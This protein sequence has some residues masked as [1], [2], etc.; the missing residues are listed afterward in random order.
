VTTEKDAINLG[1]FFSALQ[2]LAVVPVKMDLADAS[3]A[4]DTM[5]RILEERK[6][7]P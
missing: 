1:G 7:R 4:L 5:L 2:P 6:N 3:N